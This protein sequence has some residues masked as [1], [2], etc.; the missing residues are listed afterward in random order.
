MTYIFQYYARVLLSY[1]LIQQNQGLLPAEQGILKMLLLPSIETMIHD[2][3]QAPIYTSRFQ[4]YILERI[5]EDNCDLAEDVVDLVARNNGF[6]VKV[7]TAG[8]W[9]CTVSSLPY[10]EMK[11]PKQLILI[12]SEF[13][14]FYRALHNSE[15]T[16]SDG[17]AIESLATR[18]KKVSR[19]LHWCYGLGSISLDCYHRGKLTISAVVNEPQAA[20]LLLFNN[21]SRPYLFVKE[22]CRD[23]NLSLEIVSCIL[24]SLCDNTHKLIAIIASTSNVFQ[25]NDKVFLEGTLLYPATLSRF[26]E[27]GPIDMTSGYF[28][29]HS[30]QNAHVTKDFRREV[31]DATIVRLLKTAAR[32][33]TDFVYVATEHGIMTRKAGF[34]SD[35]LVEKVIKLLNEQKKHVFVPSSEVLA[36]CDYLSDISYIFKVACN[37]DEDPQ[38]LG[39]GYCYN[40]DGDGDE[41]LNT[42]ST[43]SLLQPSE[44]DSVQ[45]LPLT[46][47]KLFERMCTV[48]KIQEDKSKADE[49]SFY[50]SKDSAYISSNHFLKSFV[51]WITNTP[52][53]IKMQEESISMNSNSDDQTELYFGVNSNSDGALPMMATKSYAQFHSLL[54][55]LYNNYAIMIDQVNKLLHQHSLGIQE[56]SFSGNGTIYLPPISLNRYMACIEDKFFAEFTEKLHF[57]HLDIHQNVFCSL[58][59][60]VL[61]VIMQSFIRILKQSAVQQKLREA[62]H[63]HQKDGH[64]DKIMRLG[65]EEA[66]SLVEKAERDGFEK[67]QLSEL[68]G[69]EFE[70]NISSLQEEETGPLSS[71]FF[72]FLSLFAH[73]IAKSQSFRTT[74]ITTEAA[75]SGTILLSLRIFV[76]AC[77]HCLPVD[78]DAPVMTMSS[79]SGGNFFAGLSNSICSKNG[80]AAHRGKHSCSKVD[81]R[82]YKAPTKRGNDGNNATPTSA[83]LN[84]VP[85]SRFN[86]EGFQ[87]N[88]TMAMSGFHAAFAFNPPSTLESIYSID[89]K[90]DTNR[91]VAKIGT[92]SSIINEFSTS[93]SVPFS[94]QHNSAVCKDQVGE[95]NNLRF[96]PPLPVEISQNKPLFGSDE[97]KYHSSGGSNPFLSSAMMRSRSNSDLKGSSFRSSSFSDP[98]FVGPECSLS[99]LL[100]IYNSSFIQHMRTLFQVPEPSATIERVELPSACIS[101]SIF[102]WLD[103]I[104]I[105]L[106]KEYPDIQKELFWLHQ[107]SRFDLNSIFGQA[108]VTLDSNHDKQLTEED[109]CGAEEDSGVVNLAESSRERLNT[110]IKGS[111]D[112]VMLS[113]SK[114]GCLTTLQFNDLYSDRSKVPLLA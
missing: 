20:L 108:Y 34:H 47:E 8:A 23:L 102:C 55:R 51:E 11:V 13:E 1:R 95:D 96:P 76:L 12:Q 111:D 71:R 31:I 50:E 39:V 86:S 44:Q 87:P 4:K 92:V 9:P 67:P 26:Q 5:D 113:N 30:S 109:F 61:K 85:V 57:D 97:L 93:I 112:Y 19:R 24:K 77:C 58:P 70:V 79:S 90:C 29:Q 56:V 54:H 107:S 110:N 88:S 21:S 7:L 74:N 66:A 22:I 33:K 15:I 52:M 99:Q 27:A 84:S 18:D 73:E 6:N 3:N 43:S 64:E 40:L 35:I 10:C 41:D 42:T 91:S 2:T 101:E 38:I 14:S 104:S 32:E 49:N 89:G 82:K 25:M 60:D 72:N 46:G 103:K 105:T 63:H 45:Q 69:V 68:W 17:L 36:R 75:S 114:I 65:L 48:L 37:I 81:K 78:K 16:T 100:Q 106:H 28:S 59:R 83:F 62:T 94:K 80:Q 53:K 98:E